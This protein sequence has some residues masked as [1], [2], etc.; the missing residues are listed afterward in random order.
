MRDARGWVVTCVLAVC[1]GGCA[2]R[3]YSPPAGSFP[4]ESSR[5]LGQ[6]HSS[7]RGDGFWGGA[8]FG[9]QVSSYRLSVA[10]GLRDQVDLSL[11]PALTRIH[12]A[13]RGDT[14]HN[15]YALRA[16]IKYAPVPHFAVVGGL[17]GG[18]S[19]GGGFLSPD[20]GFIAAYENP[21][22][23][24]F[25]AARALLSAPLNAKVV[26]FTTDDDA[27][28]SDEDA[29]RDQYAL[30]PR[31]TW[32]W[33]ASAGLRVPLTHGRDLRALPALACALGFTDLYDER[34][35]T[36]NATYGGLSCALDVT[37]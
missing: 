10:H 19:V 33:Q 34:N 6:G 28:R 22:V 30:A 24:P 37:F 29:E 25:F 27:D 1:S 15:I 5:T 12:G 23:I 9:P 20:L 7:L 36:N 26:H 3:L 17:A 32:G 2:V 14:N 4:V 16:G 13:S 35:G 21:Y 18:G 11:S 8:T 31:F